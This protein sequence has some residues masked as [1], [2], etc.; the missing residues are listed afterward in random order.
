MSS[1][2][3]LP[4]KKRALSVEHFGPLLLK[5]TLC[6]SLLATPKTSHGL[7]RLLATLIPRAK[8]DSW[9][10]HPDMQNRLGQAEDL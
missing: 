6:F 1:T 4:L 7:C 3:E 2:S 5:A 9:P 8:E 10:S